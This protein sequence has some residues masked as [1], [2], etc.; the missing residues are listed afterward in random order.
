M[1]VLVTEQLSTHRYK[2][3]EGYL[4]C[5][6]AILARTGKQT[7][8]HN[9]VYADSDDDSTDVEVDRKDAE[10][11]SNEAIASFENKPITIEHPDVPIT[12][13][14]HK[15]Y[16]VGFVRDVKRGKVGNKNVLV[17]NVV[18][19]DAKAI[20]AIEDGLDFLSCGYDCDIT[21][22]D[23]PEQTNIRGNHVA[24]CSNP[25]AGITLLQDSFIEDDQFIFVT[26]E[27]PGDSMAW[28]KWFAKDMK[29][30]VTIT[31]KDRY[32]DDKV[33]INGSKTDVDKLI[34]EYN[35]TYR[36]RQLVQTTSTEINS[37]RVYNKGYSLEDSQPHII[38]MLSDALDAQ[39]NDE[40]IFTNT[41]IWNPDFYLKK[42]PRY[43]EARSAI[44]TVLKNSG[45][46]PEE[47]K[48]SVYGSI[49]RFEKNMK[50]DVNQMK[51]V[52]NQVL[53]KINPSLKAEK[54]R[55]I[56]G[57]FTFEITGYEYLKKYLKDANEIKGGLADK[58]SIEELSKKHKVSVDE[59]VEQLLKGIEVELEHT[60]D[61]DKAKEIAMDHLFEMPDYYTK[62]K[63]M[64]NDSIKYVVMCEQLYNGEKVKSRAAWPEFRSESK[65]VA[66]QFVK[67]KNQNKSLQGFSKNYYL[68]D[69]ECD[70]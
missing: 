53:A 68:F 64:E 61:K 13:E 12:P 29:L 7:Y 50:L 51:S 17:G 18:I 70:K 62:L 38:K 22:D 6:D 66:Q 28:L 31:V 60:N 8:K 52:I 10:V 19:T 27:H 20:E 25:R 34:K 11:F 63:K 26:P 5:V 32:R 44:Q 54:F 14:N 43:E 47:V 40:V 57:K 1:K 3:P 4:I 59:I 24:L 42:E 23:K 2:T 21:Q 37:K 65:D 56:A 41:K 33:Y 69:S 9:Q 30:N 48:L 16:S 49:V 39:V 55:S 35:E 45:L 15:D 46:S 36:N 67:E 58:I